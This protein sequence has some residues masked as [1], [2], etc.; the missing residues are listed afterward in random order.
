MSYKLLGALMLIAAGIMLS[1]RWIG[2]RRRTI[3]LAK[4]MAATLDR[5]AGRIRWKNMPLPRILAEV[6]D[7]EI[8]NEYF[9]DLC[10]NMKGEIPLHMLWKKE[11]ASIKDERIRDVVC[12]VDLQGDA[13]Q[14]IGSLQLAAE[15][16]RDYGADLAARQ[17]QN[18]RLIVTVCGS[19]TAMLILIL[20]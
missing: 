14:V 9:G 12:A 7:E 3:R 2:D 20:I 16:L 18:E 10:E 15:E 8:C 17:Q 1:T 19:I 5:M 4:A 6:C 13:G 11:F